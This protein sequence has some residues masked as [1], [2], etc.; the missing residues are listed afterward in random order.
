VTGRRLD[1]E[2]SAE[3]R[4]WLD[5]VHRALDWNQLNHDPAADWCCYRCAV[6][7]FGHYLDGQPELEREQAWAE[8][9]AWVDRR[10]ERRRP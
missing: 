4:G 1:V 3:T 8:H 10:L 2:L 9:W 7:A 5:S 6:S